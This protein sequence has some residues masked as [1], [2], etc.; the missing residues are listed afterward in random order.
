[1][2]SN[3]SDDNV[4]RPLTRPVRPSSPLA[5]SRLALHDPALAHSR[6]PSSNVIPT[7]FQIP[8]PIPIQAPVPKR[9]DALNP[10][11]KPFVFASSS[12]R[13]GSF[14][15]VT[16]GPQMQLQ[17]QV[18]QQPHI[19][20]PPRA[21]GH[22]RGASFGKPLNVGAPE[23]KPNA[24]SFTPPPNMPTFPLPR[25]PPA[26]P[27][28]PSPPP[29]TNVDTDSM[30]A[31][32][33][34]EKHQRRGSVGSVDSSEASEDS[35]NVMTSFKFPQESPPRKSAPPSPTQRQGHLDAPARPF[36]LPGLGDIDLGATKEPALHVESPVSEGTQDSEDD[37]A[38]EDTDGEGEES[39][40]MEHELPI[41][42]SMKARRAP[43]PLD[44]KHPVSTNTVPAGLFKALA[45]GGSGNG[46][47][48][49]AI[50]A[51]ESEERT[52][53]IVRSRL[54]SREIFEHVS[55]PSLDDLCVPAISQNTSRGRLVTDPGRWD[56][57]PLL[58][59]PPQP[60]RDRRASLPAMASA[61]SSSSDTSGPTQ[62]IS[63]RLELQ[64][65]EERLEALLESKLDDFC[66]E[67]Q[68]LW[69]EAGANGS[70]GSAST[71]AAIKDIMSLFCTQ[72]QESAVQVLDDS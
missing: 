24:F 67:V 57:P 7:P 37:G 5:S 8:M 17:P 60:A 70:M 16:L 36:T 72:L 55:R 43:I 69:L 54:S 42:L 9:T 31:Q 47:G 3:P 12:R 22:A 25:P 39:E 2:I 35:R 51:K 19:P 56:A 4:D 49:N 68:V 10:H 52:R 29:A 30:R 26:L 1:M 23:F 21:F 44:F 71:D 13:S 28:L 11:A 40:D 65:Y 58:Q 66:E 50:A 6:T 46:N 53:R 38:G 59:E 62:Y 63:R 20:Q 61:R 33:G 32:Q 34:R 45:N 14:S 64:Q 27:T 18:Q 41:P 48:N 15:P